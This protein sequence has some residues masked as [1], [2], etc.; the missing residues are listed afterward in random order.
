MYQGCNCVSQNTYRDQYVVVE[1][2]TNRISLSEGLEDYPDLIVYDFGATRKT[3]ELDIIASNFDPTTVTF[4]TRDPLC[5]EDGQESDHK[6]VHAEVSVVNSDR[7]KKTKFYACHRTKKLEKKM[8]DWLTQV[9]WGFLEVLREWQRRSRTSLRKGLTSSTLYGGEP[10]SL[11]TDAPW[12]T[13]YIKK[14]INARKKIYKKEKRGSKWQNHKKETA[15]LVRLR[16]IIIS[17]LLIW[18]KKM[19]DA[20]LYYKAVN[21]LKDRQAP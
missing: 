14:Q 15:D 8:M 5:T 12:M 10:S 2:D 17:L 3:A 13:P 16:K 1:G 6:I 21:R 9:N 20:S 11:G 7:F 18:P 19:N 4:A